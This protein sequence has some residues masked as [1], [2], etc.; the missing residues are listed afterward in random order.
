MS[1]K[2]IFLLAAVFVCGTLLGVL[3]WP[4]IEVLLFVFSPEIS[5]IER[6]ICSAENYV[7]AGKDLAVLG[8]FAKGTIYSEHIPFYWKPESIGRLNSLSWYA[9]PDGSGALFTRG[10]S[11]LSYRLEKDETA[12]TAAETVWNL[13]FEDEGRQKYLDDV[14]VTDNDRAC[15]NKLA[16]QVIKEYD[17]LIREEPGS[18]KLLKSKAVFLLNAGC[19][20]LALLACQEARRLN[21]EEGWFVLTEALLLAEK[22]GDIDGYTMLKSWV[23]SRE[24][25]SRYFWLACYCS[26]LKLTE[27]FSHTVTDSLEFVSQAC[28]PNSPAKNFAFPMA[29]LAY[30][31][32][33][34]ELASLAC[35]KIADC[36]RSQQS[37]SRAY[38]LLTYITGF[39]EAIANSDEEKVAELVHRYLSND[40]FAHDSGGN[41][42]LWTPMRI[43][44]GRH[45]VPVHMER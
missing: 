8:T 28:D 15:F 26:E 33:Q 24:D 4:V 2:K 14:V 16:E 32:N 9:G 36:I 38:A 31:N 1:R 23:D 37:L 11:H 6:K 20:D 44:I 27:E 29:V 5:M 40:S 42:I 19:H 10:F 18:L 7:P 34:D 21:P 35:R 30:R 43:S 17:K 13:L 41:L 3:C 25:F 45:A 22:K 12:S 39:Q